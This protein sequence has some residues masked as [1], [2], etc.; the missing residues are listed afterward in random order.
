L[1]LSVMV[2]SAEMQ[3]SVELLHREF[4]RQMDPAVF[5]GC[6]EPGFQ[7]P[8]PTSVSTSDRAVEVRRFRPLTTVSQN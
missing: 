3:K 2:P 4:F 6:Q 8:P 7:N 5:A 1:A